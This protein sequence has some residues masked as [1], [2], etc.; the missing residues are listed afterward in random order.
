MANSP[1][2]QT[3]DG[4]A[5]VNMFLSGDL[6]AV[7]TGFGEIFGFGT[8]VFKLEQQE[9]MQVLRAELTAAQLC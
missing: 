8:K 9:W 1:P 7:R 4:N 2:G 3:Q 6:L 5:N